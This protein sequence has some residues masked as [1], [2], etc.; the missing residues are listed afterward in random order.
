MEHVGTLTHPFD[1]PARPADA[2]PQDLISPADEARLFWRIRR[3]LWV[4]NLRQTWRNSRL[5]LVLV[6]LMSAVFWVGLFVL[7]FD[8]FDFLFGAILNE[9]TRQQTVRVVFGVFFMSLLL[10]LVFSTAIMLYSGLYRSPE[11]AFLLTTPARSERIFQHKYLETMFFSSWGFILLGSPMLLAYGLVAG[12]P[13]YFYVEV[14]VLLVAFVFIPGSVGAAA[15]MLIVAFVPRGRTLVL[16]MTLLAA[17]ALATVGVW[18]V[19]LSSTTQLLTPSWFRE[20]LARLGFVEGR[21]LPSWWLTMGLLESAEG[22]W[23]E[24]MMFAALLISNSLFGHLL[25]CAIAS[26]F[27]RSGY[28]RLHQFGTARRHRGISRLDALLERAMFFVSPKM[29]LLLIKDIRIFR[30][31]PV[32]WSQFLIFFGLLG[33]YFLNI[34]RFSYDVQYRTWVNMISFLNLAVVGLILSTF[35]NRFIFPM[36][37]LEGRRFWVL[38]RLP[39]DRDTI[40][41]SKFLFA[42]VGSLIPCIVLILIS[43]FMLRV[44]GW[45]IAIHAM[46]CVVLCSGLAGI[47]VGMGAKMPNLLEESP[48]KIAAGFGGTLNLVISTLYIVAIILMCAVPCHFY[49]AAFDALGGA[50]RW[51]QPDAVRPW[52]LLGAAGSL[53]LGLGATIFPLWIGARAFRRME[54]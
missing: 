27:Y 21:L 16:G 20:M 4:N 42:S 24:G 33:L 29:R 1:G 31:D 40:L 9:G 12:A 46:C 47:A 26:R 35:T 30:R 25:A 53:L 15:T 23:S 18:W 10:M 52:I 8:A 6:A 54:F 50:G 51:A 38:G 13:W 3:Q 2:A 41:W 44:D 48:T 5:R 22:R 14:L 32:Q 19:G 43:D 49:L 34:R 39:V 37:S 36:I 28:H 11:A 45:I 17:V 7:F